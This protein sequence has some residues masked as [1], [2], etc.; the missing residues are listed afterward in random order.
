MSVSGWRFDVRTADILS[1]AQSSVTA[2][3]L[4]KGFVATLE[5]NGYHVVASSATRISGLSATL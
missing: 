5:T 1:G 4:L 2:E 3:E